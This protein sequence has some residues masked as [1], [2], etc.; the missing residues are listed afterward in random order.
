MKNKR[1]ILILLSA[2]SICFSIQGQQNYLLISNF[3]NQINDVFSP[4]G[5]VNIETVANPSKSGENTSE[6][7][8][9]IEGLAKNENWH[10]IYSSMID[11]II[12]GNEEN[13]YR[14]AHFKVYKSITSSMLLTLK[15]GA[16][17]F[18]TEEQANQRTNRWEYI[19][20]DLL[21]G[22]WNPP[23]A[24]Q[25]YTG[26]NFALNRNRAGI[27]YVAY[28][29]DI[30]FSDSDIP[31]YNPI[32]KEEEKDEERNWELVFE[33]NFDGNRINQQHWYIY[34]FG[35]H[36]NNGLRSPKAFTVEDGL[37]VVTAQMI[38]G[39]LV[40]GGM[41]HRKNY[42]YGKFEFRVKSTADPSGA[43][44]AV[45][46]TWPQSEK[47][48]DDGE[49]DIYETHSS[50]NTDRNFFETNILS[51]LPQNSWSKGRYSIDAKEWHVVAMEWEP[52][53][54]RIYIDDILRW[55][56]LDPDAIVDKPHHLCIQLDAFKTT[57]TGISKMYV[58]WV[59]IYQQKAPMS[60]GNA[61]Q[62]KNQVPVQ[63]SRYPGGHAVAHIDKD[64]K[65]H[66]KMEVYSMEG[67]LLNRIHN[68]TIESHSIEINTLGSG[69]H[70]LKV[71]TDDNIY[72][73]KF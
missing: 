64:I 50:S 3:E 54:I 35:G 57:M 73:I 70:I 38:D 58:D 10:G 66:L 33:E 8:L 14:Y 67:T 19:V 60:S 72:S 48:P 24:G 7:V 56:L 15:Q 55:K 9:K 61:I 25:A 26:I 52:D 53:A 17:E 4:M 31:I 23:Q 45:V 41:A 27:T 43:T 42:T 29:D 37:L 62:N 34:D 47:W 16:N 59:K 44:S 65:G 39:V 6:Y 32:A 18:Y 40:S 68:G 11:K 20:I 63:V 71:Q 69:I 5:N 51:G 30:L 12:V 22:S 49:N 13:Q 36:N 1:F 2:T 46:L 21:K 28:L